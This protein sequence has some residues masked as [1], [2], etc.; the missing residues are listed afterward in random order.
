M[1]LQFRNQRARD[2]QPTRRH[3]PVGGIRSFARRFLREEDGNLIVFGV[4]VFL[5]ILMFGGIGIDLM[6]FERDRASMQYTLDRAVL[7]AADLDQTLDPE[8]VVRDYMDKAGMGS[9]VT[10][11]QFDEGLGFR[12]VSAQ[13]QSDIKT[14]FM[15]MTGVKTLTAPAASTAEE[16][17][18]GVEI[19]LV[20]DVSGSMASNSRLT[21][22]KVAAQDFV[23][24]MVDNTRDG[25]L[26]ISIVPYATQVSTPAAFLNKFNVSQEHGYSNCVNFDAADFDTT[27]IDPDTRLKRT[28]HFDYRTSSYEG[29]DYTPERLIPYPVCEDDS[30]RETLVLQKNRDILKT[31]IQNLRAEGNT[32]ID[33]GMKWG[34]AL[35]DPS[36]RPV[37]AGLIEDEAVSADFSA[38]PHA[39]S[40][41]Q[42]LKV[43]VLMTDGENTAQY[44]LPD[45]FR[46]GDPGVF[47]NAEEKIYSV[48]AGL[49]TNDR[50]GDGNRTEPSYYW[51]NLNRWGDHP[52][53]DG[54]YDVTRTEKV[55]TWPTLF[56][57]WAWDYQ[58]V[59]ETV[60][61][62]GTPVPQSKADLFAHTTGLEIADGI[63]TPVVGS[64]TARNTWY[65]GSRNRYIDASTKNSRTKAICDAAKA[66][67]IIVFT[68]GFEAPANGLAVLKDCASSD[69]HFFDVQGL[70][71]SEAFSS[72][73]SSIR[74][75]RLTQ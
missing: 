49:D 2:E 73:A 13:A 65:Y 55:C 39:Y 9:Y 46:S 54:T 43:I 16:R 17:I 29:R 6:R 22:L 27:A 3:R 69:S 14:Q 21:N 75:L 35:L 50:D 34:T 4:Y 33:V 20:L 66:R 47:W 37:I 18:D 38:R 45:E 60:A 51:T 56:G 11:V 40:D 72:I 7:A 28:M 19:S 30:R 44:Y 1:R 63:F 70:E 15:K 23:D 62:N 26:S 42:T 48:Y 59:T 31:F 32:S 12:V 53:G 52:Y 68:I 57:C 8:A 36:L 24:Q 5:I 67:D 41:N 71:I 74:K 61:E 10:G 25:N 64:T 58:T